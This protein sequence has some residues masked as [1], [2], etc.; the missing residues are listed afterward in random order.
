MIKTTPEHIKQMEDIHLNV[1]NEYGYKPVPIS[2]NDRFTN[3]LGHCVLHGLNY[4]KN[5]IE[6]S[7]KYMEANNW[8]NEILTALIKHETAHLKYPNHGYDFTKECHR[9]GLK[10]NHTNKEFNIKSPKGKYT[11]VCPLCGY[12][13]QKTKKSKNMNNT[14]CGK[15]SNVYDENK[16]LVYVKNW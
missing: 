8:N 5:Y 11:A 13:H 7:T 15:C 10:G 6:L 16:K 14:S 2:L 9:M 12:E 4:S 3:T 1:C